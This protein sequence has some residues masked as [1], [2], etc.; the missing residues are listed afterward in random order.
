METKGSMKEVTIK[1]KI[2][3]EEI[4]LLIYLP[5]TFSFLYKYN[6][7]IAQDGYEYFS[8]GKI[9]RVT[10]E[11]MQNKEIDN[12][13]IIGIPYKNKEDR[14]KKYHPN[15]NS[16]HSYI[17]FLGEELVPYIDQLYPTY[18]MGLGRILLGDSL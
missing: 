2:L 9:A 12:T 1:S 11:L 5:T 4:T 6:V 18:Q 15:G 14:W 3:S 13:I 8:I 16:F 17:R 10:E 7:L